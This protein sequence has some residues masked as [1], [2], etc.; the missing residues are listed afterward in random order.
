MKN[1]LILFVFS[2]LSSV[3]F[4]Q[5]ASNMPYEVTL[6]NALGEVVPNQNVGIQL[7]VLQGTSD[8]TVLFQETHFVTTDASGKVT[9]S[10]GDGTILNGTFD[11][12][13]WADAQIFIKTERDLAGGT[14]Y[15]LIEIGQMQF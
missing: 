2:F 9:L 3:A 1:L 6:K 8:G 11:A 14:A 7:T 10:I 4:T 5:I 12:I 13:D 15:T